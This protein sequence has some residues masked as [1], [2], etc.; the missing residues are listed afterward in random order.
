MARPGGQDAADSPM[1]G[2]IHSDEDSCIYRMG[3]R[4]GNGPQSGPE[5]HLIKTL[6]HPEDQA[7]QQRLRREYVITCS[8]RL[9]ILFEPWDF[10]C[11]P[12]WQFKLADDGWWPLSRELAATGVAGLASARFFAIAL[13]LVEALQSLHDQRLSHA[14]LALDCIWVHPHRPGIKLSNLGHAQ[15]SPPGQTHAAAYQRDVEALSKNFCTP[16]KPDLE[17]LVLQGETASLNLLRQRLHLAAGLEITLSRAVPRQLPERIYGRDAEITALLTAYRR[18]ASRRH[19]ELIL[20]AGASGLGKTAV[21]DAVEQQLRLQCPP[22]VPPAQFIRCKFEQFNHRIPLEAIIQGM[23]QGLGELGFEEALASVEGQGDWLRPTPQNRPTSESV[24]ADR[25]TL[26]A[27]WIH[28]LPSPEHPL[29]LCLDD[30]HWADP[31]SLQ[32]LENIL[33]LEAEAPL[34]VI[35]IYREQEVGPQHLLQQTLSRLSGVG[36]QT[37]TL[38]P[39]TLDCFS[40]WLEDILGQDT[41]AI[42][43]SLRF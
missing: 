14:A 5:S 10:T 13:A 19:T 20:L 42:A 16:L 38:S 33:A 4:P 11:E 7:A 28:S 30:L 18:V 3:C 27:Q 12:C 40:H 24:Q 22:G 23:R 36:Y 35:G 1:G 31:A 21:V 17:G 39:L 29:V 32:L 8:L 15:L 37:L 25:L 34:L 6:K 41:A 9:P 26:L 2:L 43:P